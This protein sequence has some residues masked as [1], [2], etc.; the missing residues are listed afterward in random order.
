MVSMIK[1]TSRI[2][3]SFACIPY[4]INCVPKSRKCSKFGVSK[5]V[6]SDSGV[7][8]VVGFRGFECF[9]V[10]ETFS[11]RKKKPKKIG[12]FWRLLHLAWKK[13]WAYSTNTST[14][15]RLWTCKLI[16]FWK[17][18]WLYT[19]TV[20]FRSGLRC[21]VAALSV[22]KKHLQQTYLLRISQKFCQ[23]P[24]RERTLR[25]WNSSMKNNYYY[26]KRIMST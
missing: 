11:F 12:A 19:S 25:E 24:H 23:N 4:P 16:R 15:L 5:K 10:E 6:I 13:M 22:S 26:T 17:Q 2:D 14:H 21:L 9:R 8:P 18:N 20:R 3:G 7:F 1:T